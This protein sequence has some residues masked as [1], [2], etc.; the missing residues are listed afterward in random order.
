MIRR[1]PRSALLPYTTL[2]RS[3]SVVARTEGTGVELRVSDAGP[4]VPDDLVPRLFERHATSGAAGGSG[5]GLYLVR[6]I[7]RGHGGRSVVHT[8]ELQSR[9][10]PVCPLLLQQ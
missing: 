8:S 1:P 3:L 2:F 5:L 10:Y 4:G 9:Q 6:E 7:V